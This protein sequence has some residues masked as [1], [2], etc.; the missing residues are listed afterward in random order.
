MPEEKK[1]AES[2]EALSHVILADRIAMEE[3]D[4]QLPETK[5]VAGEREETESV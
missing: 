2:E 1:P 5:T 4:E 3:S